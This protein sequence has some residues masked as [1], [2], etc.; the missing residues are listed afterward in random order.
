[1]TKNKSKAK[2]SK[3]LQ[4]PS[5][6]DSKIIPFRYGVVEN[7]GRSF[8]NTLS[9]YDPFH[10]KLS[11]KAKNP[12]PSHPRRPL[13]KHER[14][15]RIDLHDNIQSEAR[16]WRS[17]MTY[18]HI[19]IHVKH[20][21]LST[22]GFPRAPLPPTNPDAYQIVDAGGGKGLGMFAARDIRA[23]DLVVDERPMMVVPGSS[24]GVL[25]NKEGF[26]KYTEEQQKQILLYEMGRAIEIAWSRMPEM[27]QR[28][29]MELKNAHEQ[30]GSGPH[31][32]RTRTNGRIDCAI[33]KDISRINHSCS[34][35]VV[36][37]WHISS[38]SV[39]IRAVRDIPSGSEMTISYCRILDSAAERAKALAPYGIDPCLCSLACSDFVKS[40]ISDERRAR[41]K[42]PL[43]LSP[44]PPE[45]GE[46]PNAWVQLALTRLQELEEENLQAAREYRRTLVQLIHIR[47]FLLDVQKVLYFARK[48]KAVYKVKDEEEMP[49]MY[50]S[51]EGIERHPYWMMGE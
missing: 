35:N 1:M 7:A 36:F 4:T 37:S 23:V 42:D 13:R 43:K 3:P 33:C 31:M 50:T 27:H 41:F 8:Q 17:R 34:P 30:D 19:S 48:L 24:T 51:G 39:R 46:P 2:K 6:V 21:I 20:F 16:V 44:K 9:V 47:V 5:T 49:E 22:P 12:T 11:P 45:P 18:R 14:P 15:K 40:N 10:P 38:F 29:F 32:G 25:A 28:A 26:G